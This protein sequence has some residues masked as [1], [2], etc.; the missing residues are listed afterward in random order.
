MPWVESCRLCGTVWGCFLSLYSRRTSRA[1]SRQASGR[2]DEWR[3]SQRRWRREM[4]TWHNDPVFVSCKKWS[5]VR[6]SGRKGRCRNSPGHLGEGKGFCPRTPTYLSQESLKPCRSV[7]SVN[8]LMFASSHIISQA[9]GQFN[10][11]IFLKTFE[12][13]ASRELK[14]A[15]TLSELAGRNA[16]NAPNMTPAGTS[17]RLQVQKFQD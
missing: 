8:T 6:V 12:E 7:R 17:V 10:A 2:V 15:P 3:I 16:L 14:V 9:P 4:F 1:G 11:H 5:D 13:S